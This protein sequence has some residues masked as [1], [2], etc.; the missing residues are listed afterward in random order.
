MTNLRLSLPQE[1]YPLNW[2]FDIPVPSSH[3]RDDVTALT[4]F[5]RFLHSACN[6]DIIILQMRCVCSN[7]FR[8]HFV[9]FPI[10]N[11]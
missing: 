6:S 8:Q 9:I 2:I 10:V 5:I 1:E 11:L 4:S 3:V 7:F